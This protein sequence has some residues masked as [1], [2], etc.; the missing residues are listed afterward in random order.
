MTD[1]RALMREGSVAEIDA[2]EESCQIRACSCPTCYLCGALGTLLYENLTDRLFG[3]PGI[4]N[5][6]LC[7]NPSCGLIW[8]DPM[9]IESDLGK[10][11]RNYYTHAQPQA[12]TQQSGIERT[13]ALLTRAYEFAWR[14][15]PV[16]SERQKLELMY[17]DGLP[18]GRVLEIGCGDG[19][20]LARLRARGWDVQ[21]QEVDEEAATHARTAFGVPVFCGRLDQAG[22]HDQEFDAVVMNHVLE[23]VHDPLA[24][25]RESRRV[26]KL[27]GDLVSITPNTQG[28]GHAQFRASWNGLDRPR[29][30]FLFSRNTLE[31]MAR[32]CDFQHVKT[33]TTAARSV[34]TVGGSLR[35]ERGEAVRGI[36]AL[37]T[38]AVRQAALHATAVMARRRDPEAGDECVLIASR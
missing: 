29:H 23:H 16:Y 36:W 1:P 11:Y 3:S 14:F 6:K 19:Q 32:A 22:F 30:L 8:L 21:G 26:L 13:K 17:L 5:F 20:G 27:G 9:P 38:R 34:W 28:W 4:W 24:L 31:L 37:I 25:L 35:V 10:A 33:W 2:P 15:T 12:S 18:P 7:P